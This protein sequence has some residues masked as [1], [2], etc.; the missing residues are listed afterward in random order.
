MRIKIRNPKS[1]IR[2]MDGSVL[3]IVLW[4]ALALV[5]V[6]LYFA[7]SSSLELQASDNRVSGLGAEQAIDGAARYVSFVLAN[8]A[9]NGAMPDQTYYQVAAVAVGDSHFWL[10]GRDTNNPPQNPSGVV[11]GLTDENSKLNLNTATLTNLSMLPN[12]DPNF[13]ANIV[14]WR[15]NGDTTSGGVGPSTYAMLNP[16]YAAKSAPFE[17]VDELR[18]VYGSD[19]G[20]LVGEDVNRNGA[21][22]P[23]ETDANR[24]SQ[25]DPGILEYVTVYSQEPNTNPDGSLL[26]NVSDLS[27]TNVNNLRNLLS[28]N[29]SPQRATNI[30]DRLGVGGTGPTAA[31][32][33]PA[34][35]GTGNTINSPLMFYVQ[36]GMTEQEFAQIANEIT[37]STNTFIQG[38]ININT[39]SPAVL[40]CIPG[41]SNSVQT[42]VSYR[43]GNSGNL[44]TVAW[45]LDA[46]NQSG[47]S[48]TQLAQQIG[49]AITTKSYQFMAD[50]AALGPN[51][52]GYRRVR[53]IFDTSSGTPQIIY[54]RDLTHLGWALGKNVRQ[55]Y[56]A[57]NT[58]Q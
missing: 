10:I 5:T 16:P 38:R 2:N 29:F 42:I 48:S 33:N 19:M 12:I 44:T 11:F 39:A 13:A 26:V 24:N 46:L 37:V 15:T 1:E 23:N 25:V 41:L 35:P 7:N 51:G 34:S 28:T 6:T 50:V 20:T 14:T 52:H 47:N 21:L 30:L 36:S 18:L 22:D 8:Y 43:Q 4:I 54:R 17:S 40:A 57:K 55:A 27:G 32:A 9:T 56:L 3:I 58:Q 45:L 49:D 53:F 31:P